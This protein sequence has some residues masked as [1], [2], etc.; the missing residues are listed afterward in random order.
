MND[1]SE[2]NLSSSVNSKKRSRSFW[3]P[4]AVVSL[5]AFSA[6]LSAA[7]LSLDFS[8]R[9]SGDEFVIGDPAP[10]SVYSAYEISYPD[11]K[12]TRELEEQTARSVPP[13][14]RIR[15]AAEQAALRSHQE[16]F[17]AAEKYWAQK[18]NAP[19]IGPMVQAPEF[20]IPNAKGAS[21]FFA[22]DENYKSI[23]APLQKLLESAFS[24]G[25]F[26]KSEKQKLLDAG[27]REI[28]VLRSEKTERI[29]KTK[30]IVT[31]ED[32]KSVTERN[33]PPDV[34]KNKAAKSS[35]I[36]LAGI[37]LA[38]NV[39][40]DE[41]ET[42]L[43]QKQAVDMLKPVME[44]LK[45]SE[46]VVQRGI[47]ITPEV[48]EKLGQIEKAMA[49]R[50]VLGRLIGLFLLCG[51]VWFLTAVAWWLFLRRSWLAL[52]AQFLF[53]GCVL[54]TLVIAKSV[55]AL[56][57]SSPYLMPT[58]LASFLLILLAGVREAVLAGFILSVF[59]AALSGNSPEVILGTLLTSL[60]AIAAGIR[61]RKRSQFL[62]IGAGVGAVYFLVIFVF[63]YSAE[64][65]LDAAFKFSVL[66]MLN[67]LLITVSLAF[68]LVPLLEWIFNLTTDISLLE[69]SDL[70]HPLLKKMIVEAPGTYHH[71][72]VVSTLAESACEVI[73]ANALLARVGCYFHDIGKIARAEYFTENQPSPGATKH[74]DLAPRVSSGIIMNHVRDGIELGKKFKLKPKVLDF[75][76]EHQGTAVVYYFY[77]KAMEEATPGEAVDMNRFRYPGPKPQSRET[78]VALLA[79]SVEAASRTLKDLSPD[80]IQRLVRKIINDKF[81]DGQLDQCPLTLKDLQQIQESFVK[82]LLAIFHARVPYPE[83][84]SHP[85]Q[86][87]LFQNQ[88]QPA[89]HS[90]E[91]PC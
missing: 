30:D 66:G 63:R 88:N 43:R 9:F 24:F 76:P 1:M 42:G 35:A 60:T 58:A 37:L 55:T 18:K 16:I 3:R 67:G 4:V 71:S 68:I 69:M 90:D 51:L 50:E 2:N 87:N 82:N 54:I 11:Q 73:G 27:V 45:K 74:G 62:K 91:D 57:G 10:R 46:L 56:Q 28:T 32:L 64:I 65:P 53:H 48:K 81:I 47:L 21:K 6:L 12:A 39:G 36:E 40:R 61:I 5:F 19:F 26:D 41:T 7:I 23:Q 8:P 20:L 44:K 15:A 14:Y 25:F 17:Q 72:L 80:G 89:R 38:V 77:R 34:L 86:P 29:V 85:D 22:D 33:L 78:A 52:R 49:R 70:N 84:L 75:I 13:V 59:A 83:K 31:T 79:D